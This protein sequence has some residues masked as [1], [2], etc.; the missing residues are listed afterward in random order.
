MQVSGVLG[1]VLGVV[2]QALEFRDQLVVLIQNAH[3]SRLAQVGGELDHV[4]ADPVGQHVDVGL[5]VHNALDRALVVFIEQGEAPRDA[6][7]GGVEHGQ[8]HL[9]AA[10]QGQGGGVEEGG[11]EGLQLVGVGVAGRS[12]VADDLMAELFV[13]RQHPEQGDGA[14]DIEDGIGVGDLA[15]E[16]GHVPD[17][18]QNPQPVQDGHGNQHQGGFAQ[19]EQDVDDT[20]AAGIGAGADGADD[21]GGDAVAQIDAHDDGVDGLEGQLP[22]HGQGLQNAHGGGGALQNEGHGGAG[23]IAQPGIAAQAGEDALKGAGLRQ[24]IHR[25]GHVQQ[26]GEQDAEADGDL[27][28]G[29]QTL[30]REGHDEHDADDQ[31]HGGQ[32]GGLEHLQPGGA[33]GVQVQQTD[34]LAGDGG[35]HVRADDDADGLVQGDDARAHEA[36]GDDDGG[37]GGLDD[38]G[39]GQAQQKRLDGV[40]GHALHHPL[41]GAGGAFLQA[42]AH[43]P[44][45]VEEHGEAAQELQ[46]AENVHSSF[47]S[48]RDLIGTAKNRPILPHSI[49]YGIIRGFQEKIFTQ[50]SDFPPNFW[51][52]VIKYSKLCNEPRKT[53]SR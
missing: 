29:G 33:G 45:A 34:D 42:V 26:A 14:A 5:L 12:L 28:H 44:H 38:G 43:L 15:G 19:V 27:A 30:G 24:G 7:D 20:H 1:N 11:G 25:A 52:N 51:S 9:V 2:A 46:Y 32:G 21:G 50:V 17:A 6:V 18:V 41:E 35:A 10:V 16:D 48:P 3:M 4:G 31:R 47:P 22:G 23:H 8:Q 13:D 39:D 37:G 49:L 36:G 40:V 53:G